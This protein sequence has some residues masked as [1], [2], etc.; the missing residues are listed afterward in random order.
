MWILRLCVLLPLAAAPSMAHHSVAAAYD[1][2]E[3]VEIGGTVTA[4]AWRNPHIEIILT[5]SDGSEWE[6]STHSLSIM[7]RVG[8]SE[9]FI[10][11]GDTV[12][13]LR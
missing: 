12:S 11:V 1:P 13:T 9:P 10:E 8:A 3:T 7:R 2:S 6:L 5:A 4:I